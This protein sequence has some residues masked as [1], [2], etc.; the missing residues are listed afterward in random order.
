MKRLNNGMN[1]NGNGMNGNGMNGMKRLNPN[2]V[3]HTIEGTV[4]HRTITPVSFVDL[5]SNTRL[6]FIYSMMRSLPAYKSLT[7][8]RL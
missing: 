1:G 7:W 6:I 2:S 4:T 8:R 5:D 3:I